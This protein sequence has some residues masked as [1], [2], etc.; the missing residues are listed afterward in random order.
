M[1]GRVECGKVLCN[2]LPVDSDGASHADW[3]VLSAYLATRLSK[4]NTWHSAATIVRL[5]FSSNVVDLVAEF[6]DCVLAQRAMCLRLPI[7]PPT[8]SRR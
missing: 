4:G 1:S 2:I 3:P 7:H 8:D 6:C 5:S